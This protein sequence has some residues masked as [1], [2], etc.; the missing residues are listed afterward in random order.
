MQT[1]SIAISHSVS[2]TK[3]A[4]AGR[5]FLLKNHKK[6]TRIYVTSDSTWTVSGLCALLLSSVSGAHRPL[7]SQLIAEYTNQAN[8]TI[9]LSSY[10]FDD[11][12]SVLIWSFRVHKQLSAS[13]GSGRK[14]MI[15]GCVSRLCR[16]Q[17]R[18]S[19]SRTPCLSTPVSLRATKRSARHRGSQ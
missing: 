6:K 14:W 11:G 18:S 7:P 3:Y 16:H 13:H 15:N 1:P 9:I 19:L 5:D 4:L 17:R 10:Q 12:N 8:A 2:Y